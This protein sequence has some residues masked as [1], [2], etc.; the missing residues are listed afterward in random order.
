MTLHLF[1]WGIW[2]TPSCKECD[3]A[4][5]WVKNLKKPMNH[6]KLITCKQ[7]DLAFI[8]AINSLWGQTVILH[9]IIWHGFGNSW[10]WYGTHLKKDCNIGTNVIESTFQKVV[11]PTKWGLVLSKFQNL[12]GYILEGYQS[13]KMRP[14]PI[15]ISKFDGVHFKR[16]S[17]R[18]NEAWPYLNFIIW[19][20]T[21]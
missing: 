18:Q 7:C 12:M 20:S 9:V 6:V 16:L 17:I 2:G 19:W 15:S 13:D 1:W 4:F 10:G 5:I 11:N 21:F 14:G 3:L 8:L